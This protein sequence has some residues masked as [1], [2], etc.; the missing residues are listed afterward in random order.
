MADGQSLR[1]HVATSYPVGVDE[2]DRFDNPDWDGLSVWVATSRGQRLVALA[3]ATLSSLVLL[4]PRASAWVD[5]RYVSQAALFLAFAGAI[6]VVGL[7][8]QRR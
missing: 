4:V 2:R 3:A 1:D 8:P 6:L 7:R 5:D